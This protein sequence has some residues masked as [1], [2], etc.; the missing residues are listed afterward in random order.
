[1]SDV[2]AA[3]CVLMIEPSEVI[4]GSRRRADSSS[5]RTRRT[6]RRTATK[7]ATPAKAPP[8]HKSMSRKRRAQ[9]RSGSLNLALCLAHSTCVWDSNP[10]LARNGRSE[11]GSDD[12]VAVGRATELAEYS[13]QNSKNSLNLARS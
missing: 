11:W 13:I 9:V 4:K 12:S 7:E 1:V 3:D 10:V 5:T 2:I 6:T 8:D